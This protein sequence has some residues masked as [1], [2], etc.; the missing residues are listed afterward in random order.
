MT[1]E[2][3]SQI[4]GKETEGHKRSAVGAMK[5]LGGGEK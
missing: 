4:R 5:S 1:K 3:G 2:E